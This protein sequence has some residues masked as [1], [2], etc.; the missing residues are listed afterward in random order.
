VLV[1]S[2]NL[3][4]L[5]RCLSAVTSRDMFWNGGGNG[6]GM[7]ENFVRLLSTGLLESRATKQVQDIAIV[8]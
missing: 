1:D 4:G 3:K 6:G 8:V 7:V 2:P 5:E